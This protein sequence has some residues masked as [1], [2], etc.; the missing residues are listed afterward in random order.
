MSF[1]ASKG[2][3]A[4]STCA[5]E[6]DSEKRDAVL[7]GRYQLIF[8]TPESL[9]LNR[10]WRKML[11]TELYQQNR[12]GI[13]VDEAHCI[14]KWLVIKCIHNCNFLKLGGKV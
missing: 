7:K 11:S 8:F 5:G 3:T 9:I 14:Q 1:L 12:R 6:D 10:T 13:V 2:I 4:A